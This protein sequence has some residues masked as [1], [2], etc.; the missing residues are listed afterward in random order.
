MVICLERGADMHMAQPM[1]L[2]LTVSCFSKVQISVTFL[3][4]AYLGSTGK[5]PLNGL[6]VCVVC[7]CKSSCACQLGINKRK[8]WWWHLCVYIY[9]DHRTG[10]V[11]GISRPTKLPQVEVSRY[12]PDNML[13]WYDT[14]CCLTCARQPTWV[15]L[16]YRTETTTTTT[17]TTV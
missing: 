14:W 8:R 2:P 15:S 4:L 10:A 9:S 5:G 16:I 7:L 11:Q 6:C 3:V 17:T 12:V 13:S 1:P